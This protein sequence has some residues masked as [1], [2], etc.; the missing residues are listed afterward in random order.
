MKKIIEGKVVSIKMKNTVVVEIVRKTPHPLYKKLI[1]RD[2]KYK[3][4]VNGITVNL[5]DTVKIVQTRP[6]SKDKY[7]KVMEVVK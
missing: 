3:V 1:K 7:F 5:G 6:I 4:D 2:K